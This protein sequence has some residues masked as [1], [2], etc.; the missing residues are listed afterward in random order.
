M[1]ETHGR[2]LEA[3]TSEA[4]AMEECCLLDFSPWLTQPAFF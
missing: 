4:K 1:A 3:E 2:K